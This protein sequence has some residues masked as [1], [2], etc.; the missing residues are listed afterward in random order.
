M[1]LSAATAAQEQAT[2]DAAAADE[3]AKAAAA[4]HEA[5]EKAEAKA[6]KEAEE[7]A[8][9]EALAKEAAAEA[10][11]KADAAKES[12]DKGA[13]ALSISPSCDRHVWVS[14]SKRVSVSTRIRSE[15]CHARLSISTA[16]TAK[17]AADEAAA[18]AAAAKASGVP[19]KFHAYSARMLNVSP[20]KNNIDGCRNPPKKPQSRQLLPPR[21][22]LPRRY[23]VCLCVCLQVAVSPLF[24]L[25]IL[26]GLSLT[27]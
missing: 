26:K 3:A 17:A 22:L 7:A 15:F 5:A 21:K 23:V 10:T 16:A 6:K 9:E 12:E 20:H 2:S 8:E 14:L 13:C 11:A 25:S 1:K 24:Y 4:S 19:Q 27:I 18:A